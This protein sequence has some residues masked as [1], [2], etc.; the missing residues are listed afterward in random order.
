MT[1]YTITIPEN[2]S[3]RILLHFEIE[4]PLEQKGKKSF[5]ER[6][7]AQ[8]PEYFALNFRIADVGVS[9]EDGPHYCNVRFLS[10]VRAQECLRVAERSYERVLERAKEAPKEAPYEP[11]NERELILMKNQFQIVHHARVLMGQKIADQAYELLM[12]EFLRASATLPA[13]PKA[14]S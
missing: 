8:D 2:A 9:R 5:D 14:K 13:E 6:K 7:L 10:F 4:P 3:S 11:L 12:G 1:R